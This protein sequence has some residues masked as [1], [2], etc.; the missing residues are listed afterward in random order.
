MNPRMRWI[1]SFPFSESSS[2][3]LWNPE[4]LLPLAELLL[5]LSLP[6]S[7]AHWCMVVGV[8]RPSVS[9]IEIS[10][11]P[12]LADRLIWGGLAAETG[13]EAY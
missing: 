7:V 3:H 9:S 13:V 4:G 11:L 5:S 6:C 1:K 2:I 10:G 12:L 8:L